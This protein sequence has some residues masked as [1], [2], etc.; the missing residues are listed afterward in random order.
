MALNWAV[1]A[2]YAGSRMTAARVTCGAICLS[3]SS[4]LPLNPYSKFMKPVML[5]PGRDRLS[6]K[7]APTGS[8]TDDRQGAGDMLQC[9]H[10]DGGFGQEDVRCERNQ[11]QGVSARPVGIVLAPAEV[12]PHIAAIA[13]A[14][15]LQ[16]LLERREAGLTLRIV[17]GPA[18][19]YAD[20][21]HT[22]A[23]LRTR[24][25]RPCHSAAEPGYQFSP[26]DG[27]W[28]VTPHARAAWK[29]IT[30]RARCRRD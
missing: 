18:H 2:T 26:P 5:P 14:Q 1:P 25:E 6:T 3:C 29:H 21:P 28:H 12:D 20:A 13:P 30:P 16:G 8:A 4:H 9:R 23:L 15:L 19:E 22:P 27:D 24:C 11:F 10:A 7:P 17:C